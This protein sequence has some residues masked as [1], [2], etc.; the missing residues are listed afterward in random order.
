M[1]RWLLLMEKISW[2]VDKVSRIFLVILMGIMVVDVLV[3]IVNRFIFHFPFSWSEEIARYLLIWVSMIGAVIA[4]RSGSH[5]GVTFVLQRLKKSKNWIIILTQVM[6]MIFLLFVTI[7]GVKL[8]ISQRGQCSSA[9]R[10]SMFWPFLSIPL[11][12]ALM[13]VHL[14]SQITESIFRFRNLKQT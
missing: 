11:G 14:F 9:A 4:L 6:T 13:F 3:G 7:Y 5:V 2:W 1:K 8:C 10:V 12:S